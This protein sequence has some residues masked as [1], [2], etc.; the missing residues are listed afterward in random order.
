MSTNLT[1][2]TPEILHHSQELPV[3]CVRRS[4]NAPLSLDSVGYATANPPYKL[5]IEN[6]VIFLKNFLVDVCLLPFTF[7]CPI[8]VQSP[9]GMNAAQ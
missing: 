2:D 8:G 7:Y 5:L 4:R 6:G 3:G 1:A 9:E